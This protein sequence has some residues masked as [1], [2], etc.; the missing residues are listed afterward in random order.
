MIISERVDWMAGFFIAS[1]ALTTMQCVSAAEVPEK[2][3][4]QGRL[5]D[6]GQPVTGARTFV[7]SARDQSNAIVWTETHSSVQVTEGYY[8]LTLGSQTPFTATLTADEPALELTVTVD[9]TDLSPPIELVSVPYALRAESAGTADTVAGDVLSVDPQS[10]VLSLTGSLSV[11]GTAVINDSGQWVGDPTGLEGPPGP[12]GPAGPEGPPGPAGSL[13]LPFEGSYSGSGEAME[14]A[15][16]GTGV[17]LRLENTGSSDA[18]R[19]SNHSDDGI[20]VFN[21]SGAADAIK[22]DNEGGGEAI[23]ISNSAQSSEAVYINNDAAEEALYIDN[24]QPSREAVEIRNYADDQAVYIRQ[25]GND[26]GL[27]VY[28]VGTGRAGIFRGDVEVDGELIKSSG[29]FKIDHPLDPEN[30]YLYHSFVESPQM[31][32]VYAGIAKLGPDGT[33]VVTLPDWFQALNRDYTYQLTC[34]GGHAPVHVSKEIEDNQFVIAG[35]RDGLKVSWQVTG[36]RDDAY[37]RAKPIRVEEEKSD[38]EKGRYLHPEAFGLPESR[39]I[40]ALSEDNTDD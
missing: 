19:I 2:I 24:S 38:E 33:A 18:F 6:N 31:L 23:Y 21:Y 17:A 30:K 15:N 4:F 36:V 25:E 27:Y 32:N 1:L 14:I 9:G 28:Q 39:G 40:Q 16:T 11:G 29:S 3:S 34:I 20:A 13:S 8:S 37:A 35:G 12:Q 26:D 5:L 7:F 22:V 10:G